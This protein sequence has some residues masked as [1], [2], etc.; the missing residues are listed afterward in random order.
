MGKY[1]RLIIV[2]IGVAGALVCFPASSQ[3]Y[4]GPGAGIAFVSSFFIVLTTFFLA[5]LTLLTWP[6]RW[7]FQTLRGRRAL[8]KSRVRKVVVVGLD[9][10]DPELTERFM[11]E[12]LL[13]NFSRLAREGCYRRLGTT[14][15]A[16]SPVAWSSFQT[17]CNPGR[18]RVFDFLTPNRKSYLPELCSAK[19]EPPSKYLNLGRFRI[20]MGKPAIRFGRKSR[21]FWTELGNHGVFSTILRV[22]I[23]FPPEKF[24][25]LMLAAMSVPDLRGTQGTFSYYSSDPSDGSRFTGGLQIPVRVENNVVNSVIT[26]PENPLLRQPEEMRLPFA[27]HLN[28]GNGSC[29]LRLDGEEF[30]LPLEDYTPW[31]PIRFKPGLGMKIHGMVR[32]YLKQAAPHLKLYMSPINI[33]PEKPALPISHPL[34]YSIYL[35]KTQGRFCT[36]GLAEDTWALN[37]RVLDEKAFLEQTYLVHKE[38]ERMFFDALNKTSRGAV[39]C[40]FDITDRLQHMFF[41]YLDPDHPANQGK[42]VSQHRDAI[43]D[44][45]RNMDQ[46]V[47]RVLDSTSDDTALFVMSDHGFKPFKWGVNLNT[48]LHQNG[49]LAVKERPTGGEWFQDIDWSRTRAYAVGFGGIYINLEGRES[50]GIVT[51][52]AEQQALKDEIAS[53]LRKLEDPGRGSR[54]VGEV[55]DTRRAYAG[56]Y[57]EDGPDLIVGFKPGYRVSWTCATGAVTEEV[58][59]D[60]L[61]SWSGDHCMNPP[62][63]PGILFC[64]RAFEEEKP[65]IIDLGPTILDLFGVAVPSYCDGKSLMPAEA[66]RHPGSA[67]A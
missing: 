48:W 45:Y 40:V 27:V 57:A 52:G 41:R 63:V 59:E 51:T 30:S 49:F 14:L 29:L 10:Q 62:D 32:F 61:K 8:R 23:T 2:G 18:H 17:G 50:G 12:G 7:V 66:T 33:D 26:G 15:P 55:Y 56:P 20:P 42:D 22:P 39:V 5:F 64:N 46:L 58:F 3:A 43:R 25:G 54:P 9:G 1:Q 24:R 37:E 67:T 35:S 6:F 4:V 31:I 38:R 11:R 28:G 16:E 65:N 47:G 60:N 21:S 19:V 53:G 13:P 34:T 36:L 44:L